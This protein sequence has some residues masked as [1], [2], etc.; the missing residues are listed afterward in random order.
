VRQNN[1]IVLAELSQIKKLRL[2]TETSTVK[3]LRQIADQLPSERFWQ[4]YTPRNLSPEIK[5]RVSK[6]PQSSPVA[7][8]R[9]S[10]QHRRQ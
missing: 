2:S 1:A 3:K 6:Q 5:R 8:F 7:S 9:L 4:T 10:R